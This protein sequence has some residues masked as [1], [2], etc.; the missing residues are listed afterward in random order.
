MSKHRG[1]KKRS[2]DKF[3]IFQVRQKT[4]PL[5]VGDQTLSVVFP[6]ERIQADEDK[7]SPNELKITLSIDINGVFETSWPESSLSA[8]EFRKKL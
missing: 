1:A 6:V 7:R 3:E 8:P 4:I 2:V 5:H